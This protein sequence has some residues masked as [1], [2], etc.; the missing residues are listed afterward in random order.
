MQHLTPAL[1]GHRDSILRRIRH[2][3]HEVEIGS[4]SDTLCLS[5]KVRLFSILIRLAM[6][7]KLA[8]AERAEGHVS[9]YRVGAFEVD[10]RVG[11][12]RKQE[13]ITRLQRKSPSNY[14]PY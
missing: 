10:L 1:A 7:V 14:L 12:L 2:R 8:F 9:L 13:R 5:K 3:I 11:K 6:H 4:Q